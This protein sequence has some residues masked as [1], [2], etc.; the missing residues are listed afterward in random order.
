MLA[1]SLRLLPSGILMEVLD[2]S[3]DTMNLRCK[4]DF[5]F[6]SQ[7]FWNL[8]STGPRGMERCIFEVYASQISSELFQLHP[9]ST[10]YQRSSSVFWFQ[11]R[12]LTPRTILE[13]NENSHWQWVFQLF[14]FPSDSRQ[15]TLGDTTDFS[16]IPCKRFQLLDLLMLQI[17]LQQDSH[18]KEHKIVNTVF[19]TKAQTA[20]PNQNSTICR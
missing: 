5:N 4:M 18:W 15:K 3:S 14:L 9:S 19:S 7:V 2:S 10:T 20:K 1:K 17:F 11:L 8:F 6:H 16:S 12:L 13:D